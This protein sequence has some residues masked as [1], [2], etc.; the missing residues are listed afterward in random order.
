MKTLRTSFKHRDRERGT[1]AILVTVMWTA[2]FGMAV[3][4]VDFGYL[5]TKKRSLQSAADAALIAAM[6]TFQKQ[7]FGPANTRA[8]QVANLAGYSSGVT[9]SSAGNKFTVSISKTHPTFF[10]GIFGMASKTITAT[11][12]GQLTGVTPAPAIYSKDTA[13]CAGQWTWCVGVNVTGGGLLTING[14]VESQNKIHIEVGDPSCNG[15]NCQINGQAL[16]ACTVFSDAAPAAFNITGGTIGS[17]GSDPLGTN[18]LASLDALCT[19]GNTTTPFAGIPWGAEV[20][21]CNPIPPGVY[22]ASDAINVAPP[23]PGMSICPSVATFVSA[24]TVGIT[25]N[26]SIDLTGFPTVPSRII[27]FANGV[28]ASGCGSGPTI[29]LSNG[30]ATLYTLNG[31]IY[32]PNGCIN[33]GTGTP[34]FNMTGILDGLD[35]SIAMG[36]GQPWTFNGP[37]GLGGPTWRMVK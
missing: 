1:V 14:N 28:S 33:V 16:S 35:V 24:T 31:S 34:G 9:P 20:G 27:A 15:T 26:G 37:G 7:G 13:P 5:Y 23:G 3:M 12:T 32:A 17:P 18:T 21:G 6:P 8:R 2:L 19:V 11:A 36:P 30:P 4:A 10:G 22:C 25:A 29:Q